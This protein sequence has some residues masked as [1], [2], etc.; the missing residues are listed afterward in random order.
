MREISRR[1]FLVAASAVGLGTLRFASGGENSSVAESEGEVAEALDG[2][3]LEP[4]DV[5]FSLNLGTLRNY[6]LELTQE[7]EVARDA[8]YHSVEIWL[9]RLANYARES[10][11]KEFDREKLL[12]LKKFVDGEGLRIEGGIGFAQWLV[13][14]ASRRQEGLGELK[15]QVEALAI[16]GASCVAVPAAGVGAKIAPS[17]IAERY[18]IALELCEPFGVRP[19]LELWGHSPALSRVSD[20]LAA[21]AET[22]RDD[23]A[24]LLDVYHLYRGGNS[25]SALSLIAGSA[26]PI[27]HMNDYPLMP[28]REKLNDGNR[29]FPGDG[30]APW[31]QI[32]STLG[33][34]GFKGALSFEIFNKEYRD[35]F[36]PLEQAKIGLE[37]MRALFA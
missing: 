4:S 2:I 27:F 36:S 9:D 34:N 12:E 8:G 17:T 6:N 20:G 14:D 7:L 28:E 26:M 5:R 29:V 22:G 11:G 3:S 15:R 25:F 10:D 21:C 18:R 23:A 16:L 19:L 33:R 30:V 35:R 1:S 32:L 24:L 31:N 37:K 13:D